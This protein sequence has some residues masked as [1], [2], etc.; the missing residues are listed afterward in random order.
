MFKVG[1]RVI[2]TGP[3]IE[4]IGNRCVI[5]RIVYDIYSQ[6]ISYDIKFKNQGILFSVPSNRLKRYYKDIPFNKLGKR[7]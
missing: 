7:V 1:D 3:L 2:Y 6:N 5:H 4:D